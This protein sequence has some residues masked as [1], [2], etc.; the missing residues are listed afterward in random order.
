MPINAKQLELLQ[1]GELNNTTSNH[2]ARLLQ[3]A[4][5]FDPSIV[6]K[7]KRW[8]EFY[9]QG[10]RENNL[11]DRLIAEAQ[12]GPEGRLPEQVIFSAAKGD[13]AAM[14]MVDA[15]EMLR[16]TFTNELLGEMD[17]GKFEKFRHEKRQQPAI[18]DGLLNEPKPGGSLRQLGENIGKSRKDL[19]DA[20]STK[21]R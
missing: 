20:L 9:Q 12:G 7:M 14:N 17:K 15:D 2:S 19:L 3:D 10:G 18:L 11:L 4:A 13:Q 1:S 5:Q 8:Q 21:P 16:Q 6:G